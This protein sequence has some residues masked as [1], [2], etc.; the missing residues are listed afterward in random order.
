MIAVVFLQFPCYFSLI[1]SKYSPN[2]NIRRIS[3]NNRLDEVMNHRYP[4]SVYFDVCQLPSTWQTRCDKWTNETPT[5]ITQISSYT[6]CANNDTSRS[7]N[8]Y[9]TSCGPSLRITIIHLILTLFTLCD[10]LLRLYHLSFYRLV[11][12]HAIWQLS[13]SGFP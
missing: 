12:I 10:T 3:I 7:T 11:I 2:A 13:A 6:R 4:W 1:F 8:T 5:Q 9:H